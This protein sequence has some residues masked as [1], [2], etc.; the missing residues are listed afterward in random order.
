MLREAIEIMQGLWQGE[1][2]SHSGEYFEVETARIYDLPEEP[3]PIVIGVSGKKSATLA[4]ELGT[5]IMAVEAEPSVVKEWKRAG[6]QGARYI[7]LSI[8]YAD[9]EEQGLELAHKYSR[10]GALGWEVLAELPG[11]AAF[12]GATKY[13]KAEDLK[14]SIPHGPDLEPYV[15]EVKNAVDVGFDHV[16][17]LGVGPD[18]AGFIRFFEQELAPELRRLTSKPPSGGKSQPASKSKVKKK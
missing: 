2:F 3:V 4:G 15:A 14:D 16:V 12:E 17:L 5:G 7:E 13:I 8:A 18:Q 1:L 9:S 10:F 11:V 6:G